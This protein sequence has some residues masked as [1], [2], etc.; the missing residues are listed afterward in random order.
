MCVHMTGGYVWH[1]SYITFATIKWKH[2][3]KLIIMTINHHLFVLYL[4]VHESLHGWRSITDD[5][6]IVSFLYFLEIIVDLLC[7]RPHWRVFNCNTGLCYFWIWTKKIPEIISFLLF[8]FLQWEMKL[9][10][11]MTGTMSTIQS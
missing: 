7:M 2:K 4:F 10:I 5:I 9:L 8:L 1:S 11:I 3:K 6:F